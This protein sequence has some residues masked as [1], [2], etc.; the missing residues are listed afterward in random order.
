M[1]PKLRGRLM[2]RGISE[3]V[4]VYAL[5]Y[6]PEWF[7]RLEA[8]EQRYRVLH[9]AQ[10]VGLGPIH[11]PKAQDRGTRSW[12]Y[13]SAEGVPLHVEL[14]T[15]AWDTGKPDHDWVTRIETEIIELVNPNLQERDDSSLLSLPV[16][17]SRALKDVNSMKE[18]ERIFV[19]FLLGLRNARYDALGITAA[20]P[21]GNI[22]RHLAA[23]MD[24]QWTDEE[25][26]YAHF[27][28]EYPQ[29]AGWLSKRSVQ[30]REDAKVVDTFETRV[31]EQQEPVAQPDNRSSPV[32]GADHLAAG[33]DSLAPL[34]SEDEMIRE[35]IAVFAT[36]QQADEDTAT[37]R[38]LLTPFL[39]KV[40]SDRTPY[41]RRRRNRLRQL[42]SEMQDVD[43]A[44]NRKFNVRQIM[45]CLEKLWAYTEGAL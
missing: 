41:D 45:E 22:A 40:N 16:P 14:V 21:Q 25:S 37:L 17:L 39:A 8:A 29:M 15:N 31:D 26:V 20:T 27:K 30:A 23:N 6:Q 4:S 7:P 43:P 13:R 35:Y 38:Q 28:R 34:L 19:S 18:R 3:Q 33:I 5:T 36:R 32:N 10:R 1:L 2:Y 44:K 42:L 24:V 9:D 11:P 12:V